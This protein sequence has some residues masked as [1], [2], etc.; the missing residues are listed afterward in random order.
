MVRDLDDGVLDRP[1]EEHP[2]MR[3]RPA[4]KP[5]GEFFKIGWKMFLGNPAVVNSKKPSFQQGSDTV[6]PWQQRLRRLFALPGQYRWAVVVAKRPKA[7]VAPPPIGQHL[8]SGL[9]HALNEIF[10]ALR[11]IARNLLESYPARPRSPYFY[12]RHEHG[13][14]PVGTKATTASLTASDNEL[15]DFHLPGQKFASRSYH[16]AT[17]FVKAVPSRL[18]AAQPKNSLQSQG[19]D[20][21]LLACDPPDCPKPESKGKATALEN[22]ACRDRDIPPASPTV[23]EA[24]ACFPSL[25][26]GAAWASEPRR[27]ANPGEIILAGLVGSKP[28]FEFEQGSWIKLRHRHIL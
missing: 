23:P 14:R 21:A 12:G 8:R 15:I 19:A 22:G 28:M 25:V 26:M 18:V 4:V 27:P 13:L 2:S 20:P 6:Y 11:G 17:Q 16:G 3:G 10:Q 24:A 5:E 9:D 7:I 1:V